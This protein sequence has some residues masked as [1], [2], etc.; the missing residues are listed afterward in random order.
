MLPQMLSQIS[1]L[2]KR[3]TTFRAVVG[4][5]SCMHPDMVEEIPGPHEFLAAAWMAANVDHDGL[6]VLGIRSELL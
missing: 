6:A 3:L 1:E 4:L 5:D 2:C